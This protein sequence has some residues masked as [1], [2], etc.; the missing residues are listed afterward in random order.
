MRASIQLG[1]ALAFLGACSSPALA[2]DPPDPTPETDAGSER[3]ESTDRLEPRTVLALPTEIDDPGLAL[4]SGWRVHA[5]AGPAH[6]PRAGLLTS[7][8]DDRGAGSQT[9]FDRAG[10]TL[11]LR[12]VR[13]GRISFSL[14][15]GVATY[16]IKGG[17][18]RDA[19]DAGSSPIGGGRADIVDL[20]A[21][22]LLSGRVRMDLTRRVFIQGTTLAHAVDGVG[23]YLDLTAE[24]GYRLGPR[25]G[26]YAGWEFLDASLGQP[27]ID[28]DLKRQG[29]FARLRLEF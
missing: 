25:A 17:L 5:V 29:A 2:G 6:D 18:S 4:G 28:P 10:F 15:G 14:G 8:P 20:E 16:G 26:I 7:L 12:V 3:S 27:G 22:P 13:L 23:R 9:R 24:A 11:D 21:V 19:A 1:A